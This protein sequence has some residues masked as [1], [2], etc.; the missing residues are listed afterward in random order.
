MDWVVPLLS[1][2][3]SGLNEVVCIEWVLKKLIGKKGI[4]SIVFTS[5]G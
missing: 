4:L 2:I 5:A 1:K 3:I